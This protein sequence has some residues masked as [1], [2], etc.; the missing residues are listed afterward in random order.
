[1]K[2]K[3]LYLAMGE[4]TVLAD[5]LLARLPECCRASVPREVAYEVVWPLAVRLTKLRQQ[6]AKPKKAA[7]ASLR[8]DSAATLPDLA[9][10]VPFDASR[11]DVAL[12]P[13]V[14]VTEMEAA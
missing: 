13:R 5:E 10:T 9:R 8:P 12:V 7:G 3:H 14:T 1:M 11:W 6:A 4:A 2:K